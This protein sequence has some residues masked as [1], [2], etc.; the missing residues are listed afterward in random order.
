[1]SWSLEFSSIVW[2]QGARFL[3]LHFSFSRFL[4][5]FRVLLFPLLLL[6]CDYKLWIFLCG[7]SVKNSIGNWLWSALSLSITLCKYNHFH[8]VDSSDPGT[9]Y[10]SPSVYVFFD[11]FYHYRFLHTGI[12][13]PLV[14]LFLDIFFFLLQWCMGLFPYLNI[15]K[16]IYEKKKWYKPLFV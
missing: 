9:W 5:L 6:F 2:S 14:S 8:N 13:S 11:F 4:W 7:S 3:Q 15:I 12:L 16:A 10:M 1:M